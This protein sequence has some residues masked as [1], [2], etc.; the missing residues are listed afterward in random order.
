[1]GP[2]SECQPRDGVIFADGI[3][4]DY[5]EFNRGQQASAGMAMEMP[6]LVAEE[7]IKGC[8]PL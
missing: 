8:W 6:E 4:A 1:M 7:W 5:L 3:E 2:N